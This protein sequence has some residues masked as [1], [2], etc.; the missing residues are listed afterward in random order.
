MNMSLI[1]HHCF[2]SIA[3]SG[4]QYLAVMYTSECHVVL[5]EKKKGKEI[6]VFTNEP[7]YHFREVYVKVSQYNRVFYAFT[8][9]NSLIDGDK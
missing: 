1:F 8:C 6:P 9:S 4:S 7:Y 3:A 2:S 5:N